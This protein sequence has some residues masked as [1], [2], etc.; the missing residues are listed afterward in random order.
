MTTI[1]EVS[2]RLAVAQKRLASLERTL[3]DLDGVKRVKQHLQREKLAS[4]A[5]KTAPSDY[6]QWTLAQRGELLGCAVPH[7]CK[8]II[9]ENVAYTNSGVEDPLNSR[10]YCVV[11]QYNS[12]LDAEQLRRFVRDRIPEA[13]RPSRKKFNFQH[14]PGQVSE[15]LTGFGHNGV[16]TFGMKTRIPVIV[17]GDVAALE[18]A[19][20]WLGGG[21]ETVKLRISVKDLVK[22]LDARVADGITTLRTDLDKE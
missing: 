4:A 22:A 16:S 9:V 17:A 13:D 3:D 12:K 1:D 7:L 20:L 5:L 14:A 19:F 18:P 6:Y 15:Q 21:A 8:S 10:Y 2:A 11:L